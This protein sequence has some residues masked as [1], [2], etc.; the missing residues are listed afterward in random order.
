[1]AQIVPSQVPLGVPLTVSGCHHPFGTQFFMVQRD[2]N[3]LLILRLFYVCIVLLPLAG[4]V[5]WGKYLNFSQPQFTFCLKG[6][7]NNYLTK[8]L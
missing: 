4:W 2:Q 1:M 6:D 3:G 5:A 8:L 7:Y